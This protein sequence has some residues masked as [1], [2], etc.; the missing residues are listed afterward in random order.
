MPSVEALDHGMADAR[1]DYRR[2]MDELD[3]MLE[4]HG[5]RSSHELEDV[6]HDLVMAPHYDGHAKAVERIS[7]DLGLW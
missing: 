6:V 5:L 1:R 4:R 3:R 2:I 7:R